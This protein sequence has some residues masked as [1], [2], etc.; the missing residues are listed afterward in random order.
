MHIDATI[1]A[2]ICHNKCINVP[3]SVLI[4]T[5]I[6]ASVCKGKIM[7]TWVYN[8]QCYINQSI[9]IYKELSLTHILCNCLLTV[10]LAY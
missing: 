9:S 1:S 10:F 5:L 7:S 6:I 4:Y 2:S 3:L 8:E